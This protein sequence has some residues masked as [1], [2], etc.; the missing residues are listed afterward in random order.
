MYLAKFHEV[1]FNSSIR[2]SSGEVHSKEYSVILYLVPF[3]PWRAWPLL[4]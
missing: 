1:F 3:M 4:E 2:D